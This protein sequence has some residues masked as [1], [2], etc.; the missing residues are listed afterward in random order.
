[1][2]DKIHTWTRY[3]QSCPSALSG[4]KKV[5]VHKGRKKICIY[6]VYKYSTDIICQ[7]HRNIND[8]SLVILVGDS[9]EPG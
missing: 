9:F 1:M 2:R 6:S 7:R 3:C 5:C 4:W 8:R